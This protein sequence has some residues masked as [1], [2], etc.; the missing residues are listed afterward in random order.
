[1]LRKEGAYLIISEKF[2]RAV[3]QAV[4]LFVSETWVLMA[5]MLQKIEGVHVGFLRKMM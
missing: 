3:V 4:L 1:M 2:C 5:A